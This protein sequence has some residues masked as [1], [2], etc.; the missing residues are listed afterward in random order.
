MRRFCS[1]PRSMVV[2][3]R[4]GT[5][6]ALE[7]DYVHPDTGLSMDTTRSERLFPY[8]ARISNKKWTELTGRLDNLTSTLDEGLETLTS[9]QDTLIAGQADILAAVSSAA[10]DLTGLEAG[11][12]QILSDIADL[13]ADLDKLDTLL[14]TVET[15]RDTILA[16]Q[17][18]IRNDIA[19]LSTQLTTAETNILA[20]IASAHTKLDALETGQQE[21]CDKIDALETKIDMIIELLAG[22]CPE[23]STLNGDQCYTVSDSGANFADA[24]TACEMDGGSL[25]TMT[26]DNAAFLYGLIEPLPSSRAWIGMTMTSGSWAWTDGSTYDYTGWPGMEPSNA[27]RQCANAEAASST[28]GEWADRPCT[29]NRRYICQADI[30]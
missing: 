29:N 28:T 21:I 5:P 1:Q 14:T 20:E 12:A 25:A 23:G 2:R 16:G 6:A 8:R 11:Q 26:A 24:L 9:N 4:S 27:N 13:D 15:S 30:P 7:T 18:T 22:E 19:D 10:C 3:R 17:T